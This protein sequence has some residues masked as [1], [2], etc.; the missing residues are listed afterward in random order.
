MKRDKDNLDEVILYHNT[1]ITE[2]RRRW[3]VFVFVL[4]F[5]A[6]FFVFI[7]YGNRMA[8]DG[9]LLLLDTAKSAETKSVHYD[10]THGADEIL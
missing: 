6:V 4:L 10:W 5:Y 2:Y 9:W 7:H 3:V 8:A 1:I